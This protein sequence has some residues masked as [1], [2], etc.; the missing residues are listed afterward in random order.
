MDAT[1]V[2]GL[3]VLLRFTACSVIS[4]LFSM[5]III[6]DT[7]R[8]LVILNDS[9]LLDYNKNNIND[10]NKGISPSESRQLPTNKLLSHTSHNRK[11]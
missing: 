8:C 11:G 4:I 5:F 1:M 3:R 10:N 7:L 2:M 6:L 9:P